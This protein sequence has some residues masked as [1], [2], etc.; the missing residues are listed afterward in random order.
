MKYR[1]LN[2]TLSEEILARAD[3]FAQN[4]RYSRSG[5]IA[6]ALDAFVSGEMA[7]ES[8]VCEP[9]AVF[10]PEAVGVNP[11]IRPLVPAIIST[12]RE[13]GAV[14]AALVGSST[15]PDPSVKPRDLD[16]LV[17]F[18]AGHERRA[19]QY[20]DLRDE[21]ESRAGMPVD[22]IEVDAVKNPLLHEEFERTKVVL[23]EIA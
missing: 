3:A 22:L 14:Y 20:F 5:L 1:R 19:W 16:L 17:R 18:G 10:A 21:L 9:T 11:A 15:Q 4:E 13:H 23:L 2:I 6:A 8:V 12:C 7:G